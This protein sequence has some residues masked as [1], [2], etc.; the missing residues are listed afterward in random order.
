MNPYFRM[1][2]VCLLLTQIALFAAAKRLPA[3]GYVRE[4]GPQLFSYDELVQLSLDQHSN[5]RQSGGFTP[6]FAVDLVFDKV[7]IAKFKLDWFFVKSEL[8]QLR[9]TNGSYLFAPAFTRTMVDLSNGLPALI[10]DHSP[11]TVDLPFKDTGVAGQSQ[12]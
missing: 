2:K 6:T 11:M 5:Q 12:P 8:A 10:S 9:D 7:R 3:Q 4:S 1:R